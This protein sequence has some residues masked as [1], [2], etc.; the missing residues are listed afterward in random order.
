MYVV[1]NNL[2]W[3]FKAI[4]ILRKSIHVG[5]GYFWGLKI[6]NFNIFGVMSL[7]ISMH[8]R[9]FSKGQGTEWKMFFGLLKFKYLFG[10]LKFLIFFWGEQ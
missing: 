4:D 7:G 1:T 6:L 9:V 3:V 2:I 8:F 10:C 5:L